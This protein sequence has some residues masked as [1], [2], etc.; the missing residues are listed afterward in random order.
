MKQSF[1]ILV[2]FLLASF[3]TELAFN[4]SIAL[5]YEYID[6]AESVDDN[7]SQGNQEGENEEEPNVSK[8]VEAIFTAISAHLHQSQ[9]YHKNIVRQFAYTNCTFAGRYMS[10]PELPPELI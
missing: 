7:E 5:K 6:T 4:A 9:A 8:K 1:Y 2:F 3:I 10:I